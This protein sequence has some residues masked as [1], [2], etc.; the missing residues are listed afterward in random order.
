MPQASHPY[1]IPLP[2]KRIQES[3]AT[4]HALLQI[5]C[6]PF[7]SQPL[8][9]PISRACLDMRRRTSHFRSDPRLSLHA[10]DPKLPRPSIA[11][12]RRIRRLQHCLCLERRILP[13]KM[14]GREAAW[15]GSIRAVTR[16]YQI[17]RAR[18]WVGPC[19]A[20]SYFQR[21]V[22]LEQTSPS[23]VA[24]LSDRCRCG[25]GG[26]VCHECAGEGPPRTAQENTLIRCAETAV[27]RA[28]V[29]GVRA[30][31]SALWRICGRW[32]YG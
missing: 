9:K 3:P 10:I 4:R 12:H 27:L 26:G 17:E 28:A 1:Q 8:L 13:D 25:G 2:G 5:R 21:H 18:P 31:G 24:A 20:G 19:D 29:T 14:R 7:P 30:R 11:T 23:A 32:R 15:L 22:G 6:I 16:T